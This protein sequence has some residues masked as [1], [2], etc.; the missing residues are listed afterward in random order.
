[1]SR[2]GGAPVTG[3]LDLDSLRDLVSPSP[4]GST[5]SRSR[6][7]DGFSK[8]RSKKSTGGHRSNGSMATKR[9]TREAWSSMQNEGQNGKKSESE[10]E[11]DEK[12]KIAAQLGTS[13]ADLEA[14]DRELRTTNDDHDH[15]LEAFQMFDMDGN[16]TVDSSE[17]PQVLT[18]LKEDMDPGE[19]DQI[20]Q[21]ADKNND[22]LINYS[23][24]VALM[25]ARKR[26]V[27]GS[28]SMVHDS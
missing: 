24:F 22:G 9:R 23:E 13:V 20:V 4:H 27:H 11:S 6:Q 1:M 28:W 16:G 21:N 17:L 25:Q 14:L 10:L 5:L 2:R 26:Y 8:T 15:Y 18:F 3:I 12:Q 7:R 19:A